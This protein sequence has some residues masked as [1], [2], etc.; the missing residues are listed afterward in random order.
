MTR[1][2]LDEKHNEWLETKLKA[3]RLQLEYHELFLKLQHAEREADKAY[4]AYELEQNRY[5]ETIGKDA[6]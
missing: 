3:Y 2:T 1:T 5:V 4:E 6:K